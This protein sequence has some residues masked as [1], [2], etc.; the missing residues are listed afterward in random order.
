LKSF[1]VLKI[2]FNPKTQ[3][4][5]VKNQLTFVSKNFHP[6]D[7]IT[8]FFGSV[9]ATD[10]VNWHKMFQDKEKDFIW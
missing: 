1:V 3:V 9:V 6:C 7:Y 10:K 4:K 8:H 2:L 5:D